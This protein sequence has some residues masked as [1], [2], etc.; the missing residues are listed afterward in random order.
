M[1]PQ[2]ILEIVSSAQ[3]FLSAGNIDSPRA[4]S[5]WLVGHVL[6]LSRSELFL[7]STLNLDK[8][9]KDRL[10]ELL[11]RRKSGEPLQ[12]ITG[13][14]DFYNSEIRVGPGVLIPRPETELLVETAINHYT[15]IGGILDL[16]TGSGAI[17]IALSEE[18]AGSSGH[19]IGTDTS[20]QA[21]TWAQCN[22]EHRDKSRIQFLL[23]DLFSPVPGKKFEIVT[24][25][26]PYISQQEFNELPASVKKHEPREALL[27]GEEGLSVI[28]R[29]VTSAKPYLFK[30]GW[31]ICEIGE[32]QGSAVEMLFKS[33]N[34]RNIRIL[35]DYNDRDRIVIG[36][37]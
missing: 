29:I 17:P 11:L 16:C 1:I 31:L 23:G 21:L 37:K 2:S 9:M 4:E 5:E 13:S 30:G 18:I 6:G 7:K 24:A 35:R 8:T 19:F 12:Y 33:N 36:Q 20:S 15:G 10:N 32:T 25:N 34:W 28:F 27:A 26:P 22:L 14:T 3:A